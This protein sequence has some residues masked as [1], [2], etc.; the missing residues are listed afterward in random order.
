[1]NADDGIRYRITCDDIATLIPAMTDRA[2]QRPLTRR[3]G[4]SRAAI[5]EGLQKAETT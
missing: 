3:E 1:M 4:R 2:L 5:E